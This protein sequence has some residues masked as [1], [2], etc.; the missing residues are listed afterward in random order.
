MLVKSCLAV[1]G[2]LIIIC[3]PG[4]Q[5]RLSAAPQQPRGPVVSHIVGMGNFSH[6]VVDLDRAIA[7]Y[8]DGRPGSRCACAA[9]RGH[10]CDPK[11]RQCSGRADTG[12]VVLKVPGSTMGVELIEYRRY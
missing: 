3:A 5:P 1:L 8:R 6:I 4:V 7:F 11:S 10:S 2:A 12:P 9:V